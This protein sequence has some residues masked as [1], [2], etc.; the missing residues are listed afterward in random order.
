MVPFSSQGLNAICPSITF[1]A[2]MNTTKKPKEKKETIVVPTLLEA[3]ER[4]IAAAENSQLLVKN[5]TDVLPE[6][7]MVADGYGINHRQA[8]IFCICLDRG[9]RN[10]DY[11]DIA[12]F[13]DV[14]KVRALS[15]CTDIDALI[16]RGLLKYRDAKEEEDF[17]VPLEVINKLKRNE[18]YE[19]ESQEGLDCENVFYL[20]NRWFEELNQESIKPDLLCERLNNLMDLNPQVDFLAQLKALQLSD[21]SKM[22]LT[23]FCHL[24]INEDDNEICKR[25]LRYLFDNYSMFNRIMAEMRSGE[26]QLIQQGWIISV[27]ADGVVSTDRYQLS[28]KAKQELLAEFKLNI[29][30]EK[31]GNMLAP[32]E[33]TYKP[34]FYTEN[35]TKQINELYNVVTPQKFQLIQERMKQYN[36]RGGFACLFYGGPGTGKTETVYQLAHQTG[37][38]IMV[39]DVPQ[40][41]SKWV[42]DSEKNI[43]A[44]FD[45]Y[46]QQVKRMPL[47]PILL[48]NEADAIIGRRKSGATNAVDKMEN[49]I[50]NIILQEME[51]LEGI[52]IATTNLEENLD[53][54]FERRFLYKIKFEKPDASVRA[55]IWQQMIPEISESDAVTLADAYDLSGGQ[56]ENVARKHSI[57]VVLHGEQENPLEN[58]LKECAAERLNNQQQRTK[59][60]F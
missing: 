33:L 42:G 41:K 36:F 59:V 13:L 56:I 49:S 52:M 34:L 54:A 43:K 7:A 25:Q 35:N 28:D 46:R 18:F 48:F 24:L 17:D 11:R 32:T 1:M 47:S 51:S 53:P 55:K 57:T 10:V 37:R 38:H 45:N 50:Q 21:M 23:Y 22:M 9:P 19:P 29:S 5:L 60:G 6:I 39:V 3:I 26:H 14:S 2:T 8:I 40:I 31:I 4:I 20:L 30:T 44:L 27:C 15:Y 58:L 12:N 16:A